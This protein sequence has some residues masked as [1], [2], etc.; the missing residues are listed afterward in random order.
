MRPGRVLALATALGLLTALAGAAPRRAAPAQSAT[1]SPSSDLFGGY[2]YT[3]AGEANLHGW[4]LSGSYR[5]R[6]AL[7]LVGDLTG[8]YGS[9][10][11]AD[12]SQLAF[13]AGA[14]W[15]WRA[16]RLHPFAEGLLGGAR[17]SAS[18]EVPGASVNDADT[19]WGLA[20]GG[21]ADYS[22]NGRWAVRALVHLR[23]L[24]G[25]G[26]LDTDPRLSIGAV[27]RLGR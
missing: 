9:F 7:S 23:L 26:A 20:L 21:G 22:L 25:E 8:H 15:T 17:T 13:M 4:G 18:L 12:L 5:L 11:G 6:G 24:S 19:D 1:V 10:A 16:G 27:Y 14:R 2:S 3:H